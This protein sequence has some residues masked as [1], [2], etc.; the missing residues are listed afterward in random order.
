MRQHS[1]V[2]FNLLKSFP[3]SHP[4]VHIYIYGSLDHSFTYP[5]YTI[6]A[7]EALIPLPSHSLTHSLT[8]RPAGRGPSSEA[9][10]LGHLVPF[11]FTKWLQDTFDVP[12]VIQV[13]STI[14]AIVS[15][16]CQFRFGVETVELEHG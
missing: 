1:L 5:L 8:H 16:G 4:R 13:L 7:T 6:W 15:S 3:P 12:L 2:A 11:T 10:H 9:L 14:P